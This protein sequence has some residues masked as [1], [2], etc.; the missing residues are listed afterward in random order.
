[1]PT[2]VLT[3]WELRALVG[4]LDNVGDVGSEPYNG[5]LRNAARKVRD[6]YLS[7]RNAARKVRDAYLSVRNAARK[8]RDAYLS[9]RNDGA[10]LTWSKC[11]KCDAP[12]RTDG[13]CSRKWVGLCDGGA[14][15]PCPPEPMAVAFH[16]SSR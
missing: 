1:M 11:G 4:M 16:G 9:V 10:Q 8:V 5:D 14:G 15:D 12:M 3:D 13:N 6:A 7:V 2:I